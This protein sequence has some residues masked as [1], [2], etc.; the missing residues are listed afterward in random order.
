M[1]PYD[2]NAQWRSRAPPTC[3]RTPPRASKSIRLAQRSARRPRRRS[4]LPEALGY[5]VGCPL[6]FPKPTP[7]DLSEAP[8]FEAAAWL[9]SPPAQ[10]RA[11]FG[12]LSKGRRP[13]AAP[14]DLSFRDPLRSGSWSRPLYY[15]PC[16]LRSRRGRPASWRQRYGGRCTA[17]SVHNRSPPLTLREGGPSLPQGLLLRLSVEFDRGR[18]ARAR[19][20]AL[21]GAGA[22]A[23]RGARLR[24]LRLLQA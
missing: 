16:A 22:W 20:A 2:P 1:Y 23:G 15:V 10:M 8:V 24:L 21:L 19:F 6:G 4:P 17:G 12:D 14:R 11:A 5:R 9:I 7:A 3:R 13:P 18:R